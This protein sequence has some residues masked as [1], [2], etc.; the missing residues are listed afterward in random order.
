MDLYEE[1]VASVKGKERNGNERKKRVATLQIERDPFH[2]FNNLFSS[3]LYVYIIND[4]ESFKPK[5]TYEFLY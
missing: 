3:A 4:K 5:S 2:C 1:S